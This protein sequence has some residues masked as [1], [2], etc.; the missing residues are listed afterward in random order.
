MDIVLLMKA[1]EEGLL[2]V[3]DDTTAV[4]VLVFTTEFK[5][6]DI[7]MKSGFSIGSIL[8]KY[9]DIDWATLYTMPDNGRG[10]CCHGKNPNIPDRYGDVRKYHLTPFVAVFYK[11][12]GS[13]R[14][15]HCTKQ[16]GF[17]DEPNTCPMDAAVDDLSFDIEKLI[18]K[19][20][21]NNFE[22]CKWI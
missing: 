22:N 4:G 11:R 6:T 17:Y 9:A 20:E 12:G 16:K 10:Q 3:T 5:L 7:A 15:M 14:D 2:N 19:C 21:T 8:L 18:I 1:Q 13:W